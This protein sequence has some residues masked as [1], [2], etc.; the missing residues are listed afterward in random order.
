[1]ETKM[2]QIETEIAFLEKKQQGEG[3]SQDEKVRLSNLQDEW[4][5]IESRRYGGQC[6]S[7]F[8]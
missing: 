4:L 7:C 3:L 6:L 8:L 5:E 2:M 1:M